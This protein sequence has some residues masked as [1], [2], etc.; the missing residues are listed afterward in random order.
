MGSIML[1]WYHEGNCLRWETLVVPQ[2]AVG[3][4]Q[5][6][7]Y[8]QGRVHVTISNWFLLLQIFL[9]KIRN[10]NLMPAPPRT[11]GSCGTKIDAKINTKLAQTRLG[12]QKL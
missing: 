9:G 6:R 8:R 4:A 10:N 1:A 11:I 5:H 12:L 7:K 3:K 2:G